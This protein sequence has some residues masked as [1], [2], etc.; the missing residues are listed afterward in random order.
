MDPEPASNCG[1]LIVQV[2]SLVP[3]WRWRVAG[4]RLPGD[5]LIPAPRAAV[6]FVVMLSVH[7]LIGA[8]GGDGADTAGRTDLGGAV[9]RKGKG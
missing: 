3:E 9:G 6:S 4:D 1:S 5:V 2:P 8:E 7:L